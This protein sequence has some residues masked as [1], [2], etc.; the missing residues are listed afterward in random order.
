MKEFVEF[1]GV[2]EDGATV[3]VTFVMLDT[4]SQTVMVEEGSVHTRNGRWDSSKSAK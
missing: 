3:S 1:G 2:R 4:L